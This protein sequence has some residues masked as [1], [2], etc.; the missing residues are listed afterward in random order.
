MPMRQGEAPTLRRQKCKRQSSVLPLLLLPAEGLPSHRQEGGILACSTATHLT[1]SQAEKRSSYALQNA[2]VAE[3]VAGGR[4][5]VA[6]PVSAQV[7]KWDQPPRHWGYIR[8][9][10]KLCSTSI[11]P[12]LHRETGLPNLKELTTHS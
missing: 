3:M 8:F 2:P 7:P 9:T 4:Q 6:I 12:H 11:L 5:D 10:S 1:C